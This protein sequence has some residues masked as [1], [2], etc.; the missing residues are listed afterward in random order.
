MSG[1]KIVVG[2]PP[3]RLRRDAVVATAGAGHSS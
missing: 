2:E 3:K 1:L